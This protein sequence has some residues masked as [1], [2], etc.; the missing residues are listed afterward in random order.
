MGRLA[1]PLYPLFCDIAAVLEWHRLFNYH[2]ISAGPVFRLL[3]QWKGR[4]D[5]NEAAPTCMQASQINMLQLRQDGTSKFRLLTSIKANILF[6][7][8]TVPR[9][10][11]RDRL[12]IMASLA[13]L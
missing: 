12:D 3:G 11:S 2:T 6:G 13:R 4:S 8:L 5:G 7:A 9:V 1:V 10:Q